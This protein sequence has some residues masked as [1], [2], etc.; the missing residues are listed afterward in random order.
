SCHAASE[1][2][3]PPPM[4]CTSAVTDR[5]LCL[6]SGHSRAAAARIAGGAG[7]LFA[8]IRVHRQNVPFESGRGGQVGNAVVGKLR[9]FAVDQIVPVVPQE[10]VYIPEVMSCDA[11]PI[12]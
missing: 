10:R 1:P 11:H 8:P 5:P 2:A 6:G 3:S 4:M 9:A 7:T 12:G